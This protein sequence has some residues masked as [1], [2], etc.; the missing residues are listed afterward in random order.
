MDTS[1][2]T[3]M[4][5]MRTVSVQRNDGL[6]RESQRENTMRSRLI[7]TGLLAL[8]LAAA[9]TMNA[10]A[11]ARVA[12]AAYMPPRPSGAARVAPYSLI[13]PAAS[14][15][16]GCVSLVGTGGRAWRALAAHETLCPL[17]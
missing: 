7:S 15:G 1:K 16:G 9:L 5:N 14:T 17:R 4:A 2:T 8:A 10:I 12:H 11:P 3:S 6:Q 13:G